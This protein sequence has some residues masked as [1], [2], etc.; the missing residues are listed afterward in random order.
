MLN[1]N[2][3]GNFRLQ[4]KSSRRRILKRRRRRE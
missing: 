2:L 1:C 4:L 3:I